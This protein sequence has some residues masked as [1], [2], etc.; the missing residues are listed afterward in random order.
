MRIWQKQLFS[1]SNKNL[2]F[3]V[4]QFSEE[5][6][7]SCI[8]SEQHFLVKGIFFNLLNAH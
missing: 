2:I 4:V 6:K 1:C 8:L 3:Q 7:P 5:K